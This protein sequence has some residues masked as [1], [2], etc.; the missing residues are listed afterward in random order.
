MMDDADFVGEAQE[1]INMGLMYTQQGKYERAVHCFDSALELLPEGDER[2]KVYVRR[3]NLH[4]HLGNSKQAIGDYTEVINRTTESTT[5]ADALNH[6]GDLLTEEQQYHAAIEDFTRAIYLYPD[7]S[8]RAEAHYNRGRAHDY[9]GEFQQAIHDYSSAISLLTNG[10]IRGLAY[11]NRGTI[12]DKQS[13]FSAAV[14][15]Y[16]EALRYLNSQRH[17]SIT[18]YNRG[19]TYRKMGG[20]LN[21]FEDLNRAIL[22]YPAD[23]GV[24]IEHPTPWTTD[25]RYVT[26]KYQLNNLALLDPWQASARVEAS[27]GKNAVTRCIALV[28]YYKALLSQ[29]ANDR[30]ETCKHIE[31]AMDYD[32]HARLMAA[33]DGR[34]APMQNDFYWKSLMA[35][36]KNY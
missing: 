32:W 28:Y 26:T 4:R 11:A 14:A 1:A 19:N 3:A 13:N 16:T 18:L 30:N 9:L 6:R 24:S 7:D 29:T 22:T 17:K 23:R 8:S 15:D 2:T 12:Y 36:R 5:Q 33:Q 25:E 35:W 20:F 27:A 31:R 21:A 10:T 34:F